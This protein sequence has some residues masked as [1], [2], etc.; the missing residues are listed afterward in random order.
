RLSTCSTGIREVN[1]RKLCPQG[2]SVAMKKTAPKPAESLTAEAEPESSS[3]DNAG[4]LTL[5]E[6]KELIELVSEKEFNEFELKRGSFRLRIVAGA[7]V[8]SGLHA[9]SPQ[10]F[11]VENGP[12]ETALAPAETT[13]ALASAPEEKLHVITSPIV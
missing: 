13:R 1:L 4:H 2:Y 8:E 5:A 12:I 10:H 11:I 6:V 7:V 3:A 9:V